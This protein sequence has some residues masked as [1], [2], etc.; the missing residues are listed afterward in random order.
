MSSE[1]IDFIGATGHTLSGRLDLP[2][3]PAHGY[4]LFAHCFTCTKNSLAA[5]RIAKA[6]TARGFG[7]FRFDFT[8]LGDSGGDFSDATFSGDVFDLVAAAEHMSRLGHAP[9]LL[10]GHSLGGAAVLAA[11]ADIPSVAAV[12]VIGAPFEADHVTALFEGDLGAI[13]S[14]GEATV[15][16][17]GRPFTIRRS[18]VEDLRSHDL[19]SKISEL[20]RPLLILHAPRDQTVG[21]ENAASIFQAARH[22]KSFVSLD[23]ADHLLTD[24]KD[25]DYAADVIAAWARRYLG[26]EETTVE[27][28]GNDDVPAGYVVVEGAKDAGF[29]VR[30]TAG[31]THFYSDEPV[32]NGGLG[33]GPTPHELVSAGLGACTALTLRLYAER[34]QWPL[35][36]VRVVVGHTK[37]QDGTPTDL[38]VR[39]IRLDG[40]LDATQRD[41][42]LEIAGRCP[43]HR[44]L[45]AGAAVQT[46]SSGGKNE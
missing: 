9:K 5:V 38:F 20:R 37:R 17:G 21:I 34:K 46:H 14:C 36:G 33:S 11:A 18:F 3:G 10:V 43:V 4:A 25:A 16:L 1:Q 12:A 44:L 42:L 2:D 35:E 39:D 29:P 19:G 31:H 15:N 7:V 32:A 41:R 6:L 30:I 40:P 13:L 23:G 27:Q 28:S 22:P 24:A 45:E 26:D 8:G